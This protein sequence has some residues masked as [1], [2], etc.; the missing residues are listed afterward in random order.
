MGDI[1]DEPQQKLKIYE[2]DFSSFKCKYVYEVNGKMYGR[3]RA[4]NK[5]R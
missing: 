3:G 1:R 2:Y 4:N 5:K